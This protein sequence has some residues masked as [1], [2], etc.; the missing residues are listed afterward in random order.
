MYSEV[1]AAKEI[2]PCVAVVTGTLGCRVDR[3]V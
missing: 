1:A 3:V 2:E